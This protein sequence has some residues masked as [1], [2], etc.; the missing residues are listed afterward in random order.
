LLLVERG[1]DEIH[2]ALRLHPLLVEA[3]FKKL[4]VGYKI[5]RAH[6]LFGGCE[7]MTD[8]GGIELDIG[9]EVT[10][11][12]FGRDAAV[13]ILDAAALAR[14]V[15]REQSDNRQTGRIGHGRRVDAGRRFA[16]G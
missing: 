1:T 12:V 10:L 16:P 5:R 14:C 13:V 7:I 4:V 3:R 2:A 15:L 9:L 8:I 6:R 11:L